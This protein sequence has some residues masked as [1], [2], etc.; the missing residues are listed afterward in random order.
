MATYGV[1]DMGSNTI[2]FVVYD[3]KQTS[4]GKR[5]AQFSSIINDKV[6]ASLASYI[7]DGEFTQAGINRATKV[8]AGHLKRSEY[9]RC[10]R[11]DIFA[12]AVFRN[13]RNGAAALAQIERS[14]N[15]HITLLSG[16]DEARLGLA[17]AACDRSMTDGVMIDI[18][19]GS[20]EITRVEDGLLTH[21]VSI[22]QG[23]LSSYEQFVSGVLPTIEEAHA[24]SAEFRR[25]LETLPDLKDF[26]AAQAWGIGGSVRGSAKLMSTGNRPKCIT[27]TDLENLAKW[28]E[29]DPKAFAH[30]AVKAVPERVHTMV[31]GMIILST[32]MHELGA[33]SIDVCKHGLRE[34]YL[35]E[36]MIGR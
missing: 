28:F 18:G 6:M 3:V 9:F 5:R 7:E 29:T 22:K 36:R 24:I 13:A 23:S 8:L 25:K 21:S 2:R 35:L 20:T 32:L 11:I 15:K 34:G 16:E 27:L 17:G 10:D 14:I 30:H 26:H 19:G 31:P 12:T 4:D 1:I 33:Q